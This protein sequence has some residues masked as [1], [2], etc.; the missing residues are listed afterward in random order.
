MNEIDSFLRECVFYPCS[1]LHGLPVKL[2]SSRFP[3]FFYADYSV[4]REKFNKAITEEGFRGYKLTTQVEV[5]PD[6]VFGVR[7][8]VLKK[9]HHSTISAV[10]SE[11]SNPFVVRCRFERAVGLDNDHGPPALELM[12]SRCEA[13]AAFKSAFFRRNIAPKCLV[14]IRSGIGFGGNF[15]NYS[16][17]LAEAFRANKGGLSPF[18]LYDAMGSNPESNNY[19][20]LVKDYVRVERWGYP[21]GG[22]LTLAKCR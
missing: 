14:H 11:W 7:W 12:F 20:D 19:L 1:G 9:E 21:D 5:T 18:M 17:E 16:K 15:P 4:E 10:P 3:R 8:Q 2:L 6:S 22:H 13:I